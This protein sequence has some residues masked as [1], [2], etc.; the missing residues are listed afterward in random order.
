M[1]ADADGRGIRI[2]GRMSPEIFADVDETL[3]IRL[4][5]NLISNAVRYSSENGTVEVSLVKNDGE[6]IGSVRDFGEGIPAEALPHIW[7][8]FY[9]ADA[10]RTEVSYSG[11]VLSM[12]KWIVQAHGLDI[13]VE[14]TE[15]EGILFAFHFPT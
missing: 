7:E 10:S 1:L 11:L 8:R 4:L 6:I 15:G 5:A 2:E 14:S 12:V 9:R 3:Y 13:S